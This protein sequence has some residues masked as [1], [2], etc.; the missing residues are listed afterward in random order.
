MY[1]EKGGGDGAQAR[2]NKVNTPTNQGKRRVV[3]KRTARSGLR[4]LSEVFG[5]GLLFLR[6][7][8]GTLCIIVD[9]PIVVHSSGH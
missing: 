8:V 2:W 5:H 9:V 6:N 4:S 7:L 1:G 3:V